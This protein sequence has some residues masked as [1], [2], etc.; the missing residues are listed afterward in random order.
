VASV[1]LVLISSEKELFLC[2]PGEAKL[3]L[4]SIIRDQS[5]R[6]FL[7]TLIR[8]YVDLTNWS[9]RIDFL[10]TYMAEQV[11]GG[12]LGKELEELLGCHVGFSKN[13]EGSD[14][15]ALRTDN[16]KASKKPFYVGELYFQMSVLK[17]NLDK[18]GK[19]TKDGK[20]KLEGYEKIRVV[21]K[22]AFGNA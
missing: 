4:R 12:L 20:K 17:S 8:D 3:S 1:A 9:A 14:I 16:H 7:T 19:V 18:V 15:Q 21:G 22:G 5:V 6:N 11:D 10:S 2:A 13:L